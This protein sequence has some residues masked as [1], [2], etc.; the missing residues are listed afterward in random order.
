MA[1]AMPQL[2]PHRRRV[3]P[4]VLAVARLVRD[5]DV[6]TLVRKT[7]SRVKRALAR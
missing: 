7:G 3:P 2:S 1:A 5:G 6:R 4:E